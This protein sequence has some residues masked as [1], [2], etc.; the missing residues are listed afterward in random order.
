MID[1]AVAPIKPGDVLTYEDMANPR[2]AFKVVTVDANDLHEYLLLTD[3][4][5]AVTSDCRQFGWNRVEP[6]HGAIR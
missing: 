5:K 2:Q 3:D 4:G 6:Q 1:L